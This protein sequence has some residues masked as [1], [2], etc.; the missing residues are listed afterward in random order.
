MQQGRHPCSGAQGS[1]SKAG[2]GGRGPGTG[3]RGSRSP[4]A[5]PCAPRPP[6]RTPAPGRGS[7]TTCAR[8][9]RRAQTLPPYPIPY[10]DTL[11]QFCARPHSAAPAAARGGRAGGRT[12]GRPRRGRRCG[13]PPGRTATGS[14]APRPPDPSTRPRTAACARRTGL[15]HGRAGCGAGGAGSAGRPGRRAPEVGVRARRRLGEQGVLDLV[16]HVGPAARAHRALA[17]ATHSW[18]APARRGASPGRRT[19]AAAHQARA[20][21]PHSSAHFHAHVCRAAPP[22]PVGE[23]SALASAPPARTGAGRASQSRR[24]GTRCR[25]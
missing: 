7:A 13:P 23:H 5:A 22:Q 16:L 12:P 1:L 10:H 17:P 2:T 14:A 20:P 3:A 9:R 15:A 6:A 11:I 19:P 25:P 4:A 8:A 24:P 21:R 18:Q